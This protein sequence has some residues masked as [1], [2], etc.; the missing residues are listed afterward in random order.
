MFTFRQL[1]FVAAFLAGLH[2]SFSCAARQ[3]QEPVAGVYEGSTPCGDMPRKFLGI[4]VK[5]S[6]E[7]IKWHFTFYKASGTNNSS[8][9]VMKAVYGLTQPNTQGFSR[10]SQRQ[11]EGQWSTQ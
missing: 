4:P 10:S 1:S 8:R 11:K 2:S 3:S 9:F 5:D 6:C 7:F